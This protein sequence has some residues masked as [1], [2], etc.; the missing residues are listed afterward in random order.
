MANLF[1][2][3]FRWG[4]LSILASIA[5]LVTLPYLANIFR[6]NITNYIS[7]LLISINMALWLIFGVM[8]RFSTAGIV[9]SG[10]NLEKTNAQKVN[11]SLW[12]KAQK[13]AQ[14]ELGYSLQGGR[15]IKIFYYYVLPVTVAFMFFSAIVVSLLRS[16]IFV[17]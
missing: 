8:W 13:E 16:Q 11:E 6:N 14:F 2:I 1:R 3:W 4:F 7:S 12:I 5:V 10:E 15:I 17:K 9:I